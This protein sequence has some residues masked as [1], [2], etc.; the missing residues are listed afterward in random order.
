M[1][2]AFRPRMSH[3]LLDAPHHVD[4][5]VRDGDGEVR[6]EEVDQEG[7]GHLAAMEHVN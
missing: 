4:A 6:E 3:L 5:D 7:H 2:S 1:L